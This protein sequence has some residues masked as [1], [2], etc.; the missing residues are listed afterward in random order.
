MSSI[1]SFSYDCAKL[2]GTNKN[3][4]WAECADNC[5][6]CDTCIP[7]TETECGQLIQASG[8]GC[9]PKACFDKCCIKPQNSLKSIS[10][11]RRKKIF[12]NTTITIIVACV[13]CVLLVILFIF[14]EMRNKNPKYFY[15]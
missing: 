14:T 13:G 10:K 1:A 11:N 3:S 7:N 5:A 2:I 4:G 15:V 8:I 9:A 6:G 12:N